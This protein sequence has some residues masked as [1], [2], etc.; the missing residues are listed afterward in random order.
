[1]VCASN[2]Q[3]QCV[4]QRRT[5]HLPSPAS[6]LRPTLRLA[7]WPTDA[8]DELSACEAYNIVYWA[9]HHLMMSLAAA[10]IGALV[11]SSRFLLARRKLLLFVGK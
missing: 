11:S 10:Q 9:L 1:M 8:N 7:T 6:T 4:S 5:K 3:R 2:N